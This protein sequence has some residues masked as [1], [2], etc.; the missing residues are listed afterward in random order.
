MYSRQKNVSVVS[1]NWLGY[2]L[3]QLPLVEF[4]FLSLSMN[5]YKKKCTDCILMGLVRRK[6][7]PNSQKF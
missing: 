1:P 2:A 3:H 6:L 5:N 4:L 7:I